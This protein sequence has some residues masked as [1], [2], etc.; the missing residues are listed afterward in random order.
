M[1]LACR[2]LRCLKCGGLFP[3]SRYRTNYDGQMSHIC[4]DCEHEYWERYFSHKEYEYLSADWDDV[5]WMNVK[6]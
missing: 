3:I 4:E 6:W 2:K 1:K 5:T